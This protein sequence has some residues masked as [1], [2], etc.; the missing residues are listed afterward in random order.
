MSLHFPLP[1]FRTF[2]R[3]GSDVIIVA[4]KAMSAVLQSFGTH[5]MH[6]R[7][8]TLLN[9]QVVCPPMDRLLIN[10]YRTPAHLVTP[11]GEMILST[12]G[13]TQ[14]DP[15]AMAMYAIG[16]APLIRRLEA[17]GAQ[18]IWFADDSAAGSLLN[19]RRR[20]WDLLN[21]IGPAYGY[22]PNG[23]KTWLVVKHALLSK[24][25]RHLW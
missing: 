15:I 21:E 24:A 5:P 8:V 1:K 3:D 17:P 25:Q 18:Q 2:E 14:G 9:S 16:L 13:T 11:S 12:E 6:H 23:C 19:T 4:L 10:T 7:R 20:W 22:Y